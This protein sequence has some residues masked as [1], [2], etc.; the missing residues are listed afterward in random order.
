MASTAALSDDGEEV[1]KIQVR[2][3]SGKMKVYLEKAFELL[4][5]DADQRHGGTKR[6]TLIG[7]GECV[8]RAISVAEMIKR[9]LPGISLS[10]RIISEDIPGKYLPLTTV[11]ILVI[12]TPQRQQRLD[13]ASL[14]TRTP[15]FDD[16]ASVST[17]SFQPRLPPKLKHVDVPLEPV[18]LAPRRPH[19][20][21]TLRPDGK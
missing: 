3:K 7:T 16:V 18:T 19:P 12:A 2:S 1:P 20:R 5:P 8:Y 21:R 14:A 6:L 13:D 4:K 17:P 15:S 11:V 9:S 10:T